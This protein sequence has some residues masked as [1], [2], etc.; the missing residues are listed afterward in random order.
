MEFHGESAVISN[1]F[2][3][4]CWIISDI[5]MQSNATQCHVE[6]TGKEKH[7]VPHLLVLYPFL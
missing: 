4:F 3:N 1:G 5:V 6:E 2:M 7:S